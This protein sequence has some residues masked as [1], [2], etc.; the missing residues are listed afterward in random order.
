M[1]ILAIDA[2]NTRIKWGWADGQRWVR[3]SS[4]A[5]SEAAALGTALAG[6]SALGHDLTLAWREHV[7]RTAALTPGL[8]P[9]AFRLAACG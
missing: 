1:K 4:V 7:Q 2:G 8:A 9:D 3:Q 5:T 6:L